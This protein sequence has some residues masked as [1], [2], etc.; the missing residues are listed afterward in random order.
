VTRADLTG[1]RARAVHESLELGREA[2]LG[3][4]PASGAELLESVG[5]SIEVS[6]E[7]GVDP[8]L[9]DAAATESLAHPG[10]RSARETMAAN[11]LDREK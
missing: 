6:R 7:R 1:R 9:G 10:H 11:I 3:E 8:P 4:G 2:H 5:E